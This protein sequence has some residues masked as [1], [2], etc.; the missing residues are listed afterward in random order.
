V[1]LVEVQNLRK[2]FE[3]EDRQVVALDG[4][5]FSASG[6]TFVSIVGPSGCGKSTL[7]NILAGVETPTEGSADIREGDRGRGSATS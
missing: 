2:V 5:S 1:A 7:L 3:G 6:H 4:V